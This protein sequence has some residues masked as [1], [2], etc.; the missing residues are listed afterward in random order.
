MTGDQDPPDPGALELLEL[1]SA[2]VQRAERR[3]A[4]ELGRGR[5]SAAQCRLLE[6]IGELEPCT[7]AQLA[8]QTGSSAAN[9]SQLLSKLE[10]S[11]LVGRQRQGVRKMIRLTEAG[12]AELG[13]AHPARVELAAGQLSPL[14]SQERQIMRMWLER[15]LASDP[16]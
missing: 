7:Q 4:E 8:R 6:H 15:L 12:L 14:T 3:V 10:A 13:R 2:F 5:L 16:R 1:M 11:G 9:I